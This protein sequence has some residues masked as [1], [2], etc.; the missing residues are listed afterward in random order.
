[1][2]HVTADLPAAAPSVKLR[3]RLP[4]GER[5]GAVSTAGRPVP[6]N[7]KTAT[8]DLSGRSGRVELDVTV[9]SDG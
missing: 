1:M 3:L 4:A 6:R 2:I 5:I 9:S 8:L 7:V